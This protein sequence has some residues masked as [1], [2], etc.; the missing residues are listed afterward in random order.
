MVQLRLLQVWPELWCSL[1][2]KLQCQY[3]RKF[4]RQKYGQC[5]WNKTGLFFKFEASN[6]GFASYLQGLG[7]TLSLSDLV[8]VSMSR[9]H[10]VGFLLNNSPSEEP[11]PIQSRGWDSRRDSTKVPISKLSLCSSQTSAIEALY[12]DHAISVTRRTFGPDM[13]SQGIAQAL[14]IQHGLDSANREQLE[15][16]WSIV[17]RN[18]WGS[19]AGDV[20][21]L[22]LQCVCGYNTEARQVIHHQRAQ[23]K[24]A[25]MP[26]HNIPWERRAPYD[27]CGC[28]GHADITFVRDTGEIKRL[29]GVL[30]H[31]TE[32][33]KALLARRP[34]IPLHPHVVQVALDQLSSGASITA[35]QMRNIELMQQKAYNDQHLFNP[36]KSNHRFELLQSDFAA[37]YRA[38]NRQNGIDITIAPEY[39]LDNWLDP[40]HRSFKPELARAIFYYRARAESGDRLKVC[41]ST[42]EMDD[43]AWK[44]GHNSQIILDG[45]FGVCSTRLLLFIA[46]GVD[47]KNHG[48]PLSLLLFSAPAGNR[49]TQAGYNTDIL[50]EL[51]SQWKER[52]A[53]L[54]VWPKIVLLL[55]RFHVRQCW[56]NKRKTLFPMKG[57]QSSIPEDAGSLAQGFWRE[58]IINRIHGL[59]KSLLATTTY[60]EASNLVSQEQKSI[61]TIIETTPAAAKHGSASLLYLAYLRNTW[62]EK[63]LWA[64]WSQSGRDQAAIVLSRPVEGVIPTTNHLESFNA[65]LKRKYIPRWQRSGNRLRFDVFIHYLALKIL[66]ELFAQR[67]MKTHYEA[68]V[69]TRF[70]TIGESDAR[71]CVQTQQQAPKSTSGSA[72]ILAWFSDDRPR[73][74]K[75]KQILAA[76][77]S[78]VNLI[79]S[80]RPYEI[81]ATCAASNEEIHNPL[82]LRYWLTMHPSGSAT[83]TCLDWLKFGGACKHLR[84]LRFLVLAIGH[85]KLPFPEYTFPKSYLEAREILLR[86][87]AWYGPHFE[88]SVTTHACASAIANI[89]G[90]INNSHIGNPTSMPPSTLTHN[91]LLSSAKPPLEPPTHPLQQQ[92]LS[93]SLSD[94]S[95]FQHIAGDSNHLDNV[96]D[97]CTSSDSDADSESEHEPEHLPRIH[98]PDISIAN[99]TAISFQIDQRLQHHITRIIPS[100]HNISSLLQE[101]DFVTTDNQDPHIQELRD[102]I[103]MLSIRLNKPPH[104]PIS[105]TTSVENEQEVS[106]LIPATTQHQGS[107]RQLLPPSPESKQKRK[108]SYGIF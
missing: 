40:N 24:T 97:F 69:Q 50:D 85:P 102:A 93:D 41:I 16:K 21:R 7:L 12:N 13:A 55:C 22:L 72:E 88:V 58:H 4:L 65:V 101:S 96:D 17:W 79:T 63:S 26:Q 73:D 43:A 23:S 1:D 14:L 28:L 77:P 51:L 100:L 49:A 20:V 29:I 10:T 48:V 80:S 82:H 37:L 19:K 86:N 84:A 30:E 56:T 38:H 32:C 95:L 52:A 31:N 11:L 108:K 59:E 105:A 107:K 98:T 81:W 8:L 99:H 68:W 103:A 61:S 36:L 60:D 54:R 25:E 47:E 76:S 70:Q 15:S 92:N 104:H 78:R 67:R 66:P 91:I 44:Y 9:R 83:C 18:S 27:Y 87:R 45:T 3:L 5:T 89:S 64:S 33:Q 46:M 6:R 71:L 62:L 106:S 2:Q 34:A 90:A 42:K 94:Q 75:A 57:S 39:N 35:V 74:L 53:L